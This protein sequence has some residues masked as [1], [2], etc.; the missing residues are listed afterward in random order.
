MPRKR[1]K[2][3]INVSKDLPI[4]GR[5][6]TFGELSKSVYEFSKHIS[7]VMS[8]IE[9]EIDS[10]YEDHFVYLKGQRYETDE[11]YEKNMSIEAEERQ[12]DKDRREAIKDKEYKEYLRLKEKFGD[13]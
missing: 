1:K 2:R 4:F 8:D 9:I 11:E 10:G 13:A 3:L 7:T 5:S 12:R 6:W